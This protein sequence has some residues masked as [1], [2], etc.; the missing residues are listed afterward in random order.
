M[1]ESGQVNQGTIGYY[2]EVVS[3]R[4]RVL[5]L[6]LVASFLAVFVGLARQR[7]VFQ[8]SAT[9]FLTQEGTA[10]EPTLVLNS[11]GRWPA[12]QRPLLANH[13]ELLRSYALARLVWDTL[14]AE[15]RE[16]VVATSTPDPVLTLKRSVVVRAVRDADVVR[17]TVY[18]RSSTQA[19]AICQGYL[20]AYPKFI[21]QR[22]CADIRAV[23]DFIQAQLTTVAGRL[24]SAAAELAAYQRRTGMADVAEKTRAL[25]DQQ[26]QVWARLYNTEAEARALRQELRWLTARIES[27]GGVNSSSAGFSLDNT[28]APLVTTLRR[29]LAQLETERTSLLVQGYAADAPRVA[30]LTSRIAALKRELTELAP[31]FTATGAVDGVS[32]VAALFQRRELVT[33]ELVRL[34]AQESALTRTADQLAAAFSQ[35]PLQAQELARR[36]RLVEADRQLYTLLAQRYEEARIQEAGRIA[37]VAVVDLPGKGVQVQPNHRNNLL[38]AL[39]FGLVAALGTGLVVDR[40]DTVVRRPDDLERQGFTLLASVPRFANGQL[41]IVQGQSAAAE[42]FRVLRTNLV[43]AAGSPDLKTVLVTSAE[44]GE[45]KSI[46][47]ANLA[48]VTSQSGMRTLLIDGD[49]R[50]PRLHNFYGKKKRPGLTDVVLLNVPLEQALHKSADG[51]G[52]TNLDILCA[53]TT[54]PA[55]TDFLNSAPLAS[56]LKE[57]ASR[58]D[59]IIID[60][61]PV[62]VAADTPV[63]AGRADGVVLVARMGKSDSRGLAAAQKVLTQSGAKVL[64]VVANEFNPRGRYGYYRYHYHSY[65]CTTAD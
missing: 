4:A 11:S 54:P 13:I 21:L 1:K 32:Q 44:K 59:R 29:E 35:L 25:L 45:G 12:S 17:L 55:P 24:D 31:A 38:L 6:V 50:R 43:F 15:V 2:L 20:D 60:T 52:A 27:L 56:F 39:I 23:K 36:Y 18:A 40:L 58:Y 34:A 48:A 51:S 7:P 26:N 19:Q 53:G 14:P 33:A 61:P 5:V 41:P 37:P 42:A 8:S 9:L 49:L 65:Y 57:L 64:G 16:A 10:L 22:N 28:A 63:L 62:L 3:R 47:A 46:V 30:A